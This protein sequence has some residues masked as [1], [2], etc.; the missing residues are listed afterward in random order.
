MSKKFRPDSDEALKKLVRDT[1]RAAG[2]EDPAV[3]PHRVRQRLKDQATGEL[4]V[5]DYVRRQK[6]EQKRRP[7]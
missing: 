5:D 6:A 7:R 3:P 1:A 4:G 2:G